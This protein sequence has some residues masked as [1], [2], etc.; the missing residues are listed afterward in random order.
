MA[1]KRVIRQL[2]TGTHDFPT[3]RTKPL[4]KYVDKTALLYQLA[5]DNET[6][7][8]ISRPRRFGKSLM[9]STLQA[10]FEGRRELFKGLK[11]DDEDWEGW[12]TPV[13]VL[14]FD[15]AKLAPSEG[16]PAMKKTLRLLI[17]EKARKPDATSPPRNCW[18]SHLKNCSHPLRKNPQRERSSS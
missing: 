10:M 17:D 14:H 3:L 7:F 16:I 5:N 15:M 18:D 13:P 12:T 11:I 4:A 1:K 2:T 6:Q 8:F 9:L